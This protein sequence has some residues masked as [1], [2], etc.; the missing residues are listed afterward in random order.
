MQDRGKDLVHGRKKCLREINQASELC[1]A[2]WLSFEFIFFISVY[3]WFTLF[4]LPKLKQAQ[5]FTC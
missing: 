1:V 4:L 2:P 5:Q 3:I